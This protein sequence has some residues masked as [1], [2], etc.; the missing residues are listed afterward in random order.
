M[1]A[2][3]FDLEANLLREASSGVFIFGRRNPDV[4]V[5]ATRATLEKDGVKPPM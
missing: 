5:S 2:L 1:N 4:S 3:F